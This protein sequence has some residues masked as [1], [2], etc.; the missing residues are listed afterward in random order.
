[1]QIADPKQFHA[2]LFF[3]EANSGAGSTNSTRS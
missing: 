1:L 2:F 3:S